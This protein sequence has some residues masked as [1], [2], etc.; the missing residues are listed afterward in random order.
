MEGPQLVFME[1]AI[2][3]DALT[4]IKSMRIKKPH[5]VNTLLR[6]YRYTGSIETTKG[7]KNEC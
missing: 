5:R 2:G 7:I 1:N 4:V 3:V 6:L